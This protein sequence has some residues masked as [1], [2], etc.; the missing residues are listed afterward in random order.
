MLLCRG[1]LRL[2]GWQASPRFTHALAVHAGPNQLIEVAS[3]AGSGRSRRTHPPAAKKNRRC[4]TRRAVDIRCTTHHSITRQR[5]RRRSGD[6]ERASARS[7]GS[8][9]D[10]AGN[11]RSN[12]T[13][14]RIARPS[15][16]LVELALPSGMWARLA[17]STRRQGERKTRDIHLDNETTNGL[18]VHV[19]AHV[20]QRTPRHRRTT[21]S[22]HASKIRPGP[23]IPPGYIVPIAKRSPPLQH[24]A[25]SH[26]FHHDPSTLR[27]L[28]SRS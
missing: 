10:R 3:G 26:A 7:R 12:R 8:I 1:R 22:S 17:R 15:E 28:A 27:R 24:R 2:T 19:V 25:S 9:T 23:G 21:T 18:G 16:R 6:R 5:S 11:G 14:T 4:A 13:R 20:L